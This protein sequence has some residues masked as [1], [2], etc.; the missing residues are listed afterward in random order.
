MK[1]EGV[2]DNCFCS[3]YGDIQISDL[4]DTLNMSLSINGVMALEEIYHPDNNGRVTV[5]ELGKVIGSYFEFPE[6]ND[7]ATF[8]L[9]LFVVVDLNFYSAGEQIVREQRVFYSRCKTKY[10]DGLSLYGFITRYAQKKTSANRSEF[11]QYY[12]NGQTLHIG[13]SYLQDGKAKYYKAE[14]IT[15]NN[16]SNATSREV[17]VDI[18]LYLLYE[19]L[20][21][22]L[23]EKELEYY[24]IFSV[25]NNRYVDKIKFV[26]DR[27]HFP[28][29]THLVYFNA[30]GFLETLTFTGKLKQST[31]LGGAYATIADEYVKINTKPVVSSEL[32]SGHIDKN[33]AESIY[34][35][36]TA[37]DVYLYSNR[38]IKQKM[39]V[40][41]QKIERE[42]PSNKP[43]NFV[44]TM[45]PASND[46]LAF[47]KEVSSNHRIFDF[48]FDHTFN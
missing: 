22:N 31:E 2:K 8:S 42:R 17:S 43:V 6:I 11:I 38:K 13:I 3:N 23:T 1:I 36:I 10:E 47:D 41:G 9:Q 48:T 37:P 44:I 25:N 24:E 39:V 27:R 40:T 46:H 15:T 4:T 33:T 28:Q 29:E 45:R 32:N 20:G 14:W 18:I 16:S 35:I 5:R 7:L 21:L 30:F 34:D 12:E 19:R 26:N